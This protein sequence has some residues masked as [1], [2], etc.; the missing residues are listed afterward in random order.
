[1]PSGQPYRPTLHQSALTA[2]FDLDTARMA[3]SFDKLWRD[4]DSLLAGESTHDQER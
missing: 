1:M 3:P 2:T 4:V